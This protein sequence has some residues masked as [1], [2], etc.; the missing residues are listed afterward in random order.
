MGSGSTRREMYRFVILTLGIFFSD[1]SAQKNW[2]ITGV[3]VLFASPLLQEMIYVL[4]TSSSK[5]CL[6]HIFNLEITL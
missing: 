2:S 6:D 5:V 3:H 4:F 1:S